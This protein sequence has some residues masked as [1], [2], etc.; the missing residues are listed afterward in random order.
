M[1]RLNSFWSIEQFLSFPIQFIQR[2]SEVLGNLFTESSIE[3]LLHSHERRSNPNFTLFIHST[4]VLP[5]SRKVQP[6]KELKVAKLYGPTRLIALLLVLP[7]FSS[8]AK[9]FFRCF[10]CMDE[11]GTVPFNPLMMQQQEKRSKKT[12][13]KWLMIRRILL[14]RAKSLFVDVT[15]RLYLNNG[16]FMALIHVMCTFFRPLCSSRAKHYVMPKHYAVITMT[17]VQ[18][19]FS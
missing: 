15:S 8:E 13:T 16:I 12:H 17:E 6:R 10:F 9:S 1:I 2:Q 7:D 3:L 19:L 5:R 4:E 18:A 14:V 11:E